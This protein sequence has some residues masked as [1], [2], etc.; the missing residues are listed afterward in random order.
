MAERRS[1]YLPLVILSAAIAVGCQS[2]SSDRAAS[3]Q[4]PLA[5]FKD[6]IPGTWPHP[7]DAPPVVAT[8][9]M[10][11]TDAPLATHVGADVLR[12]GGNAIDA[13]VATAFALAVVFPEAGNIGGG[14]FLVAKMVDSA[15]VALDFRERAPGGAKRD[16]YIG[17]D[18]KPDSRSLT[19]DLAAGVPGSVAGLYEAH[20]RFGSRPWAELLAPA[21]QLA[22]SGFG[23]DSDFANATHYDSARLSMFPA[24][25]ALFLPGGHA[26]HPGDR[27]RNPQLAAVLRRI[28]AKGPSGFYAGPTAQAITA[29]MHRGHGIISLA[30][31]G[32]YQAKWRTPV[33]FDY[34]GYHVISMP[35]PSSGGM[36]IA[37]MAHILAGR[38]LDS[39]GWHSPAELHLL[40]E[41]MRRGFAVRNHFLGDP[42]YISIPSERL[43]SQE[44]AD[45][46]AATIRPDSATP[47]AAVSF[48]TGAP[49][50]GKHT[51]HFS[52]VDGKGNAIA[53]TTT[54]NS[55]FGSA[56][57]VPGAGFL[58]NNEMDDFTAQPGT[59]NSEGLVMGDANAIAPGKRMLSSMTP[60]IVL[61]HDGAPMLVTGAS[62]G[63]HIITAVFQ[64]LS[65]VTDFGMPINAA[66]SA[67]R[68]H[69]QH[70]PDTL[71]FERNGLRDSAVGALRAMGHAVAPSFGG[72]GI[73]ASIIRTSTGIAGMADPRVHGSAEGY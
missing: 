65:N 30:D 25:A 66:V 14:G 3:T 5:A 11:A 22:D 31:L 15:P 20:R 19:G 56:S 57:T 73:G 6:A 60:T 69:H 21:I 46:L 61:G 10:V 63:G 47:S 4:S 41:A 58:L 40:A 55:G 34:R 44:F 48:P 35:P 50:E 27:W 16:M 26:L 8:H 51:T 64:V 62:G 54:I 49:P 67:P 23:A 18:G 29:E 24:S 52:V 38:H 28:A 43:L 53:L 37:L 68:V 33:T 13:A 70:L 17:R 1:V 72:I 71:I 59:A 32:S 12:K 45:S 7:I 39:L 2:G 9:G 36:T 42:G